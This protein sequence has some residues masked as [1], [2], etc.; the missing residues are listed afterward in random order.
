MSA[1]SEMAE[2]FNLFLYRQ[3]I[4]KLGPGEI[5][6]ARTWCLDLIRKEHPQL[7]DEQVERF[8]ENLI[9]VKFTAVDEWEQ[10]MK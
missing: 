3:H 8:Y 4:R 9:H 2:K 1:I 10:R 7:N 5:E 6:L